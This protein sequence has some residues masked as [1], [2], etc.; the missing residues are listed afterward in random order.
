[1]KTSTLLSLLLI[2]GSLSL[3]QAALASSLKSP[4]SSDSNSETNFNLAEARSYARSL[5]VKLRKD[6]A[7]LDLRK[8]LVRALI[9]A[10]HS[11][12]AAQQMHL[13][14]RAGMRSNED[15]ALLADCCRF[16]GNFKSAIR[17]YQESLGITPGY[18][19][20]RA[21]M[22]LSYM[23]A[24]M[25]NLAERLCKEAMLACSKKDEKKELAKTLSEIRANRQTSTTTLVLSNASEAN[26]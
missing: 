26:I 17:Y 11:K 25:F 6:P 18:A 9:N 13:L 23:Q 7:N 5:A 3:S 1:M 19:H 4:I 8:D 15:F 12:A 16:S 24:G 14:I 10:G 2:T 20:A 22:A 21:G